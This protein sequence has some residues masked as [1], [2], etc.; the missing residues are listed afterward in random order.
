M[1]SYMQ[2]VSDDLCRAWALT[3]SAG[4]GREALKEENENAAW[5]EAARKR[6]GSS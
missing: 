1:I 4:N 6:T 5:R 3:V 2:D